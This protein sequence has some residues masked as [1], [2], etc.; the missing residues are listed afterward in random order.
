MKKIISLL[1]C[2]CC[3]L[4]LAG[5][6][7][8]PGEETMPPTNETTQPTETTTVP[9]ETTAPPETTQ[10]VPT[11]EPL[12]T[13]D[14][15]YL[16]LFVQ[17]PVV[18]PETSGVATY[19]PELDPNSQVSVIH[20]W[21]SSAMGYEQPYADGVF[22][23][24][25]DEQEYKSGS[26][27]QCY[28]V[29]GEKIKALNNRTFAKEISFLEGKAYLEFQYAVNGNDVIITYEP[30]ASDYN[31]YPNYSRVVDT[32]RGIKEILVYLSYFTE[33]DGILSYTQYFDFLN[34]ET[35]RLQGF[36]ADFDL[37]MFDN[38]ATW[39]FISWTEDGNPIFSVGDSYKLLNMAEKTVEEYSPSDNNL[40]YGAPYIDEKNYLKI[41]DP[42]DGETILLKVPEEWDTG[43][44]TGWECSPDGRK[45][46]LWNSTRK[47]LLYDGDRK[48]WIEIVRELPDGVDDDIYYWTEDG[49][50][51]IAS[52]DRRHVFVYRFNNQ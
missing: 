9:P 52:K 14:I 49:E 11:T 10:P 38:S 35:G 30:P 22:W 36:L 45:V 51:V 42:L 4:V 37:S 15:P 2:L 12:V 39:Y 6:E 3:L 21:S 18:D 27:F 26:H 13:E 19:L 29:E 28:A 5:C 34:L 46:M 43:R 41:T 20:A 25:T 24:C 31:G 17:I 44:I 33:T 23:K 48:A 47:L 40:F 16:R 8:K 50:I 32:S 7:K 1:V